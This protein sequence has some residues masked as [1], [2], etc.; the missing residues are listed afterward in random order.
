[1]V[2]YFFL[3]RPHYKYIYFNTFC[4]SFY[5]LLLFQHMYYYIMVY[6]IP[7]KYNYTQPLQFYFLPYVN[8]MRHEFITD[9]TYLSLLLW[10]ESLPWDTNTQ[11]LPSRYQIYI[12]NICI[13]IYTTV[14]GRSF[15]VVVR[16]HQILIDITEK[17]TTACHIY[18]SFAGIHKCE[19]SIQKL[20]S[21]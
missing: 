18:Y 21:F 20:L 11:E 17:P 7:T 15:D 9:R 3:L 10:M 19:I 8:H 1:M 13:S 14:D 12:H 5:L 6:H 2:K 4:L 16:L